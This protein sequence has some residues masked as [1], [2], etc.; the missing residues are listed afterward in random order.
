MLFAETLTGIILIISGVLVKI[1]PNLIAGYN[2]LSESDKQKIDIKRLSTFIHNGL[3]L[4][5]AVS[6]ISSI[7]M[8]FLN[9]KESYR[10]MII[11]GLIV[12]G[13]LYIAINSTKMKK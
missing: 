5:G 12:L 6:I 11:V 3:I 2:T 8:C 13:V 1:N 9:V 10:L 7:T 4:I